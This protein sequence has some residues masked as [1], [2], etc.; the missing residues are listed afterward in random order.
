MVSGTQ[1]CCCPLKMTIDNVR[2]H[3]HGCVTIKIYSQKQMASRIPLT[4]GVE[5]KREKLAS[6]LDGKQEPCRL[7]GGHNITVDL[8]SDLEISRFLS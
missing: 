6:T 7:S 3:G 5:I 8:D 1:L 4:L 2:T